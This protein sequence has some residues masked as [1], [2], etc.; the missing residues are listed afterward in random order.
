MPSGKRPNATSH[1]CEAG[2]QVART[3]CRRF[4]RDK[5]W[6]VIG[7]QAMPTPEHV[8]R[9]KPNIATSFSLRPGYCLDSPCLTPINAE[10]TPFWFYG[11]RRKFRGVRPIRSAVMAFPGT[12]G[13][14]GVSCSWYLRSTLRD[15]APC[16]N[17]LENFENLI[18]KNERIVHQICVS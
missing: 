8:I 15:A 11:N 14:L 6:L 18:N 9:A 10:R 12:G 5:Q 1:R 16:C 17:F 3:G 13:G 4:P 7:E 2:P